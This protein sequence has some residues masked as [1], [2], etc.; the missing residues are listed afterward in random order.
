MA[1]TSNNSSAPGANSDGLENLLTPPL[2]PPKAEEIDEVDFEAQLKN[3]F[4]LQSEATFYVSV[5]K[6]NPGTKSWPQICSFPDV[7]DVKEVPDTEE[8]GQTYGGGKYKVSLRYELPGGEPKNWSRVFELDKAY[9]RYLDK[10]AAPAAQNGETSLMQMML[11]FNERQEQASQRSMQ[12]MTTL[13]ANSQ[14]AIAEIAKAFASKPAEKQDINIELV[15]ELMAS[16]GSKI[17]DLRETVALVKELRED[18][19]PEYDEG[20]SEPESGETEDDLVNKVVNFF[21]ALTGGGQ[22]PPQIGQQ[23][24]PGM[25]AGGPN[26]S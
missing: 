5:K 23:M 12:M 13:M 18:A 3:L 7:S 15:R 20:E 21:S 24:A 8:I 16:K 22:Q 6:F 19:E 4:S 14:T 11:M 2:P 9:D 26:A 1:K 25:G 10:P 17:D